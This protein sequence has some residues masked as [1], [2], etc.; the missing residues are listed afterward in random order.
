MGFTR[1][2]C[3]FKLKL[4]RKLTVCVTSEESYALRR[5]V[6]F[7]LLASS[8]E[9]LKATLRPTVFTESTLF[10]AGFCLKYLIARSRL[11]IHVLET[12]EFNGQSWKPLNCLC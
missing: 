9:T 6:D 11:I 4:F 8:G 1:E 2:Q 12:L 5:F 7:D 3:T 10:C